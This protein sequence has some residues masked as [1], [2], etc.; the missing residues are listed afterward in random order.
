MAPADW[1]YRCEPPR[2]VSL[3]IFKAETQKK[4]KRG[5]RRVSTLLSYLRSCRVQSVREL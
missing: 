2:L 1:D 5:E 3:P 4:G